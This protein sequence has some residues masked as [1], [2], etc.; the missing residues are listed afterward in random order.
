MYRCATVSHPEL[1]Q[2][3][4]IDNVVRMGHVQRIEPTAIVL[5]GGSVPSSPS[6]LYIDC[7]GRAASYC[8]TDWEE[9]TGVQS[10]IGRQMP[11]LGWFVGGEIAKVGPVMQSHNWT[12][13][14]SVI[15]E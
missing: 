3:R 8:G 2:L 5:D 9:A 14:L 10:V 13:I 11:L 15:C 7:A 1:E 6:A 12:G 4:R